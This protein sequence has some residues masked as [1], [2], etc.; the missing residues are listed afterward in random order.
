LL[1]NSLK[2]LLRSDSVMLMRIGEAGYDGAE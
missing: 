1:Q 2:G